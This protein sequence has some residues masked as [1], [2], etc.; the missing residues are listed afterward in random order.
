MDP[1]KP[2]SYFAE[3]A[4]YYAQGAKNIDNVLEARWN[5]A[6]Q[7]AGE[8]DPQKAAEADRRMALCQG[9]PFNSLNAKTSP[10][11]DALFGGHYFTNRSD[12]DLHC[13]ICSCDIDYKVLSFR[14]DNMCGLSYYNQNNPGNSQPLK[15]EAFAG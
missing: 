1:T 6:L 9:C 7:T 13:S 8:L 2:R 14:T 11:F 10:E 15:W 3:M 4:H 5:K 12:Q